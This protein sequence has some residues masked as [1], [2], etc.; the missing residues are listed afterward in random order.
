MVL[1]VYILR[2][3]LQT[4]LLAQ[5]L[6]PIVVKALL[7]IVIEHQLLQVL[8]LLW[9][10]WLFFH[11]HSLVER[12]VLILLPQIVISV[13]I[14]KE[15]TKIKVLIILI[16]ELRLDE[17]L[18][19][20]LLLFSNF[21]FLLSAT[22]LTSVRMH[23]LYFFFFFLDTQTQFF[24]DSFFLNFINLVIFIRKVLHFVFCAFVSYNLF[25]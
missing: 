17:R 10:V 15:F 8:R 7:N 11:E 3:F 24:L 1:V 23:C 14:L 25:I 9:I 21:I 6:W 22:I 19:K 20:H 18:E 2:R 16:F 13:L 12:K 5:F 4:K